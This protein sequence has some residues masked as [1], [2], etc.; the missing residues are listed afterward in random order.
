M[1]QLVFEK[2]ISIIQ[3]FFQ[4]LLR[5]AQVVEWLGHMPHT[6]LT[7]IAI[8]DYL[9]FVNLLDEVIPCLG[10]AMALADI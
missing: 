6:Q 10:P 4:R 2:R 8:A 1:K 7:L 3:K 9:S 5:H